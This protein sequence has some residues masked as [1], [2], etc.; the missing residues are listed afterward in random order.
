MDEHFR[1]KGL[2]E[3]EFTVRESGVT[4]VVSPSKPKDRSRPVEIKAGCVT[5]LDTTAT[6]VTTVRDQMGVKK[7]PF[8]FLGL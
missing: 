7:G 3:D 5:P 2:Q 4:Y 8:S 1:P 6:A